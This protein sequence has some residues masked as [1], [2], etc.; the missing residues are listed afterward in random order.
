AKCHRLTR[1]CIVCGGPAFSILPKA[2]FAYLEPD[3]GLAG[4]AAEAF[5]QLANSLEADLPCHDLPGMVYRQHGEVIVNDGRCASAFTSP[6]RLQ[7]LD[8]QKYDQ[9]GFGLGIL[10]KLGSFAYPTSAA[11]V[12]GD[13]A[14][15][16]VIRPIDAVVQDVQEMQQ[17]YGL[18]KVF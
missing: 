10:T 4:D 1:P 12:Q 16:R 3:F 14:A 7:E 17:Q 8:M 13:A 9:A 5:V 15:W 18:R 6:P 11:Q 2:I